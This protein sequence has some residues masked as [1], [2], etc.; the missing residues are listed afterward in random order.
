MQTANNK[1]EQSGSV[2]FSCY[3]IAFPRFPVTGIYL[4]TNYFERSR[5]SSLPVQTNWIQMMQRKRNRAN[6][7][8]VLE[9]L[10]T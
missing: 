5:I 4:R 9:L 3:K 7:Q 8:I 6:A 1:I 10:T 2:N